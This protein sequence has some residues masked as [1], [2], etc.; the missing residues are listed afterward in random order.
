MEGVF[1]LWISLIKP[2]TGDHVNV[3]MDLY[4]FYETV[5]GYITVLPLLY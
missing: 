5:W 4:F 3:L 1:F 2:Y